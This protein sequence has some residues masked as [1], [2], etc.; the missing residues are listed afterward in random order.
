ME[1]NNYNYYAVPSTKP[2]VIKYDVAQNPEFKKQLKESN[3]RFLKMM[4]DMEQENSDDVKVL[5]KVNKESN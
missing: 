1:K 2:F 5:K 4:E 3:K